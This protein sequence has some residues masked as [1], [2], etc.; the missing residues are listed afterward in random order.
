M[1]APTRKLSQLT[2]LEQFSRRNALRI[3]GITEREGEDV[4]ELTLNLVSSSLLPPL[5]ME[6]VDRVHRFGP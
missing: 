5:T 2:A 6:D 3:S 4:L 1:K